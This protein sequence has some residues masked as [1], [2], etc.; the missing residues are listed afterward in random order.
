MRSSNST[1]AVEH[2][3]SKDR[4]Q[5]CEV[6]YPDDGTGLN[7]YAVKQVFSAID[8]SLS[9]E[10]A[11]KEFLGSRRDAVKLCDPRTPVDEAKA[12]SAAGRSVLLTKAQDG[13]K[14]S[15]CSRGHLRLRQAVEIGH[16]FHL[17]TRYSVPLQAHVKD[18]TDNQV[19]VS[20]GCH[21]IGVSRLI[22]AIAAL[23][24][25][26]KGL[27]WPLVISPFDLLVVPGYKT[28]PADV[29]E[30]YDRLSTQRHGQGSLDVA[31]DD[32]DKNMGFKLN[33]ADLIGYPFIVVMGKTWGSKRA[34]E[35]QSRRLGLKVEVSENDLM[36]AVQE[37][38]KRL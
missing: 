6:H 11:I 36:A 8:T 15:N 34:V 10:Q 35:L 20:M 13:D 16:T 24:K 29:T 9:G 17:G 7:I 12:A 28:S 25:D 23:L 33:D 21:G 37:Y 1:V 5:L 14:C 4:S 2:Y 27:N 30:M 31:I 3:V 26:S 22:G 19:P 38:S 32:R 18:A